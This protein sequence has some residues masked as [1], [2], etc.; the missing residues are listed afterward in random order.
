MEIGA[1]LCPWANSCSVWLILE[2]K[3][4]E[5]QT[6]EVRLMGLAL[7]NFPLHRIGCS[8]GEDTHK[9]GLAKDVLFFDYVRFFQQCD[10]LNLVLVK[11][12]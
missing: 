1:L 12:D 6:N 9:T 8:I 2:H 10:Y 7:H 3:E 4:T 11:G 5:G